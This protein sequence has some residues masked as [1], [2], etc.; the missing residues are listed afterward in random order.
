MSMN[1][2]QGQVDLRDELKAQIILQFNLQPGEFNDAE[3]TKGMTAFGNAI[4]NVVLNHIK[5]N[6]DV[7][8]IKTLSPEERLKVDVPASG[9]GT[10]NVYGLGKVD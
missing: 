1:V 8:P 2:S 3:L 4:A 7:K 9:G 6:A 10:A 5:N